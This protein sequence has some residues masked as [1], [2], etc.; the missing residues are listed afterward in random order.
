MSH[1]VINKQIG[2][3]QIC[4]AELQI[5]YLL[6]FFQKVQYGKAGEEE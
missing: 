1:T 5:I 2:K 4:H 3:R 6:T